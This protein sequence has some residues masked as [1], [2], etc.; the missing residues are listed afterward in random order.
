MPPQLFETVPQTAPSGQVVRQPPPLPELLELPA[1]DVELEEV[2]V[3]PLLDEVPLRVRQVLFAVQTWFVA[4]KPQNTA[5]PQPSLTSLQTAPEGHAVSGTQG[6]EQAL[7]LPQVW[8]E[9][10]VPQFSVP[11]QPFDAVPQFWPEGHEVSGTQPPAQM[12]LLPQVSP[13]GQVPQL[14]VPPQP[15][16]AV[17][18]FWPLGQVERGRQPELLLDELL[19]ELLLDELLVEPVQAPLEPQVPPLGHAPSSSPQEQR[20]QLV[21]VDPEQSASTVPLSTHAFCLLLQRYCT[22]HVPCAPTM[23]GPAL[24]TSQMSPISP[25]WLFW[26]YQPTGAA[27]AGAESGSRPMSGSVVASA[28]SWLEMLVGLL[29]AAVLPVVAG[30]TPQPVAHP[31]EYESISAA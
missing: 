26:S 31:P 3:V 19:D 22:V 25:H 10:Q 27:I 16:D 17:P 4:Q 9:G 14:S 11:P 12:L 30:L 1:P 6:P 24:L 21:I 23:V 2:V 18:Q 13:E 28:S 29:K 15:F 20:R 8:P 5:P 7:L